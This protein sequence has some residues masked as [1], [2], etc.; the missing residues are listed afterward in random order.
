MTAKE[1]Y[2]YAVDQATAVVVQVE[3]EQ[4]H[5][6]T[7]DTEWKVRDL[8]QHMLYELSWTPDVVAGKTIAE[9]GD[10]YEGDLLKSDPIES[11]RRADALT[12]AAVEMCDEH[13]I[14]HLSYADKPVRDYLWEAGND[15]LVHAWDLGQAIGVSVVFDETVAKA[16][17]EYVSEGGLTGLH[18][19]LFGPPIDVP[20]TA[21]TQTKLL[22]LLGRS[23]DWVE[24][25]ND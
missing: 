13:T 25:K 9:T 18:S 10:K 16:L 11:W 24:A 1:L 5:L 17:Y 15:Q 4:M 2:L 3:P 6:P 23:E 19:G 7:P 12:Q 8:L 22:G 20:A 14:A 21:N